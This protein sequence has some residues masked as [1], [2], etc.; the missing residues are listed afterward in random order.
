MEFNF[1]DKTV[2]ITGAT[3][4]IGKQLAK[5]FENLG[6]NLI[7]TGTNFRQTNNLNKNISKNKNRHVKYYTLDF[8]KEKSLDAFI[9]QLQKYDKIDICI[10]NAGINR[11]N[12]FTETL[13]ED[14]DDII[15]VNLRSPFV[16]SRE[17]AKIMKKNN[18]GRIVNIASI[19][20]IIS[21]E[22]RSI[23]TSSKSGLI[24]M[25]RAVAVE[26]APYNILVN[27]VSPG[28]VLTDLTKRILTISEIKGLESQIPLR[29]LATPEDISKVVLFLSS[30]L[31]TYISGQN[32][33][34]DGG[35]V[36]I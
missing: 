7:L 36:N 1:K 13:V 17:A 33:I 2:L 25:T 19:F 35:Y 32:I 14:W 24:G 10:N 27:C 28:F 31:N 30:D 9:D 6:A 8:L 16:L 29:R 11:I 15:K 21:R 20:G 34:V 23:Y 22:K 18:Y 3:R 4:G 26:L 5:D 12:Y